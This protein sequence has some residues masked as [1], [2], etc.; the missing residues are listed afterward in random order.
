MNHQDS[1]ELDGD[2]RVMKRVY[3]H[4]KVEVELDEDEKPERVAN[5]IAR[6]IQKIYAVRSA[7]LTSAVAKE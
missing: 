2:N 5:E 3:L 6:A 1:G 7:E 4:F